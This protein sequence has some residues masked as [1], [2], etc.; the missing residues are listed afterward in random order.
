MKLIPLESK[1]NNIVL[2]SDSYPQII[3]WIAFML[4]EPEIYGP[5]FHNE[6]K[7][8]MFDEVASE[9][10]Q[11]SIRFFSDVVADVTQLA[12]PKDGYFLMVKLV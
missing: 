1:H 2:D 10:L 7:L 6:E 5:D 9:S 3:K 4:N 8:Y 12:N 11:E